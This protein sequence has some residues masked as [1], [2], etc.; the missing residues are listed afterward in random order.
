MER[1]RFDKIQTDAKEL[2]Y[3]WSKTDN[4]DKNKTRGEQN[5]LSH[6]Y[7]NPSIIRTYKVY[8]YEF[9]NLNLLVA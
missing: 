6:N 4:I 9:T 5:I 7:D 2:L 8:A 1:V 3:I